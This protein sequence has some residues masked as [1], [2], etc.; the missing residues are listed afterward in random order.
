MDEW[1]TVVVTHFKLLLTSALRFT[2]QESP[3]SDFEGRQVWS[4]LVNYF[5]RIANQLQNPLIEDAN[6]RK[7]DW[8]VQ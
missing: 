3:I 7:C 8:F 5:R 1:M 2:S 4:G 6:D